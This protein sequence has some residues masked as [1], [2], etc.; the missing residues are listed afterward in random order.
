MAV[1][2]LEKRFGTIAVER[3]FVTKTQL[4]EAINTQVIEDIEGKKHRLIGTILFE[5]GVINIQ[6][7]DEVLKSMGIPIETF[8]K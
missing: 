7:I 2:Q 5:Q 3:E 1:E 8:N 4:I 6:Q